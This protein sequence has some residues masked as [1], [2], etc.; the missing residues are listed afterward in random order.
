MIASLP[1]DVQVLA[2]SAVNYFAQNHAPGTPGSNDSPKGPEFGKASPVGIP[3]VLLL[4]IATV[5]LIFNMNKHIKRLP[6]SFDPEHP[7]PDQLAD[8]GT[9]PAGVEHPE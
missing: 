8:E 2:Y 5:A 9:D 3:I 6:E 1:P 4:L 7:E